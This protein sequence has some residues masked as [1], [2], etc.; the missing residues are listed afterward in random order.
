[1]WSWREGGRG[2]GGE[3]RRGRKGGGGGGEGGGRGGKEN[4]SLVHLVGLGIYTKWALPHYTS[5]TKVQILVELTNT[6]THTR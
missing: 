3:R 2:G 5:Y 6:H 4:V 1:M